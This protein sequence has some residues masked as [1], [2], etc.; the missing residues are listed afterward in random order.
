MVSW[1]AF[2][3]LPPRAPPRVSLA[4]KTPFPVKR[5]PRRRTADL[6]ADKRSK[7]NVV[8]CPNRFPIPK[9][10]EP[11]IKTEFKQCLT[12]PRSKSFSVWPTLLSK[13]RLN[14]HFIKHKEQT[15]KAFVF[16]N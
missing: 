11:V 6:L 5:L 7:H 13:H 3:S 10:Y 12:K 4:P 16:L 8:K 9:L 15:R 1:Q 2:C 14:S